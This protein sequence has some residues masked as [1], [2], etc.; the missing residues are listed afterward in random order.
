ML[1]VGIDIGGTFTDIVVYDEA[2]G[3]V[4][5]HEKA[6]TTYGNLSGGILDCLRAAEVDLRAVGT[7]RHGTTLVINALIERKGGPTA[8]V[9]TTGFRDV[10]EI[11]RAN[12][13]VMFDLFYKRERPLVPRSLRHEVAE[14]MSP[15]GEVLEPVDL[16]GL[17]AIATEIEAA[18][19]AS[20]AVSFLNSYANPANEEAAAE[21]LRQLLPGCFVSTGTA[22]SRQW[23]E[24]ER[25]ATAAAN[26]YVGAVTSQYI[27]TLSQTLAADGFDGTLHLMSSAGGVMPIARAKAEPIA[28]VESGPVGGCIG[29]SVYASALGID[30]LIAFD[31]GGTTAKCA[32]VENG[33]FEIS[34]DYYVGGYEYGFPVR[35]PVLEIVEV[36]AGGGSIAWIDDQRR[37]R[38]GPRSAGSMP[39]PACYGRG[40][41]QPTVTDANLLLGRIHPGGMA[42]SGVRLDLSAARRAMQH[43]VVQPLANQHI[44]GPVDAAYGIVALATVAMAAAIKRITV[45]RGRDPREY[46]LFAYGGGGPLHATEI[47]RELHLQQVVIPPLPGIFAAFGMLWADVTREMSR[48]VRIVLDAECPALLERTFREL[49]AELRESSEQDELGLFSVAERFLEMRYRGQAHSLRVRIPATPSATAIREIFEHAYAERYGYAQKDQKIDIVG[50]RLVLSAKQARPDLSAILNHSAPTGS[51]GST[52]RRNIHF[53]EP[54]PIPADVYIRRN[55][56]PGFSGVGPCVIEESGSTILIHPGDSFVVG[57][58][59][60]IHITLGNHG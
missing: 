13:P 52:G 55:L 24:Y 37:L 23:Y 8:L 56:P 11:G 3:S 7:I 25:T 38:L 27:A 34:P 28:L 49:D 53:G 16:Q 10:L 22:I 35:V 42:D 45:E 26:A 31:M 58:H 48:T 57:S 46:T 15:G 50:L 30:K 2:S 6:L 40:G 36:G 43:H 41:E 59:S 39:G 1:K 29:A 5:R 18:G 4:L 20:V 19:C 14:R 9:T 54:E 33:R 32:L 51:P 47:A 60:E 44:A 21:R 17:E 12:R